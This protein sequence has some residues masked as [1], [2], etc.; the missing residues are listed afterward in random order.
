M[1]KQ[2]IPPL[3]RYPP[4]LSHVVFRWCSSKATEVEPPAPTENV[5]TKK[6]SS[7]T[8]PSEVAKFAALANEWWNPRGPFK[9]LHD[10]NDARVAFMK[11]AVQS[12]TSFSSPSGP[13][14]L[15]GLRLLDVGCGGGILSEALARLGGDVTGIDVTRENIEVAKQHMQHDPDLRNRL[16]YVHMCCARWSSATLKANV[17]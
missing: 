1:L 8:N 13:N 4:S 15:S 3:T 12:N 14:V 7:S 11:S 2:L 10:L 5:N 6:G 17:K 16:R 9:G